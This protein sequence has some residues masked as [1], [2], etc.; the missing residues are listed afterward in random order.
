MKTPNQEIVELS[1]DKLEELLQRAEARQFNE[2]D[3]ET[4]KALVESYAYI[5]ELV[6]DKGIPYCC[7]SS[8]ADLWDSSKK[9][10]ARRVT[11][12]RTGHPEEQRTTSRPPFSGV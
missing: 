11:S 9:K 6:E 4:I 2:E 8:G 3:Y 5:T 7:R 10:A 12:E 1:M